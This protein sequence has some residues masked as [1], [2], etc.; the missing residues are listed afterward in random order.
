MHVKNDD[1]LIINNKKM[2]K[3]ASQLRNLM[4]SIVKTAE[5]R[6]YNAEN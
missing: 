5:K 2:P 6:Y 4:I 3:M 1:I